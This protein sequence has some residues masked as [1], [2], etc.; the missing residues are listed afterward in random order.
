[1]NPSSIIKLLNELRNNDNA[2]DIMVV[3]RNGALFDFNQCIFFD[4][5]IWEEDDITDVEYATN[6]AR[7]TKVLNMIRKYHNEQA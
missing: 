2:I 4:V 1:M 7:R 3:A 5:S 6:E